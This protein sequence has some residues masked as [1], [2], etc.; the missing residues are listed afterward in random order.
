MECIE[1]VQRQGGWGGANRRIPT[2]EDTDGPPNTA[3]RINTTNT[4][5]NTRINTTNTQDNK[6]INTTN[7][8]ANTRIRLIH[9]WT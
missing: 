8:Q 3:R 2:G 5:D 7:T 9:Y 4:Q 1:R 6:R